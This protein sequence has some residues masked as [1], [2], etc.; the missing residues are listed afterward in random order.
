MRKRGRGWTVADRLAPWLI[1][2]V[3]IGGGWLALYAYGSL[4][5]PRDAGDGLC[6]FHEDGRSYKDV[7]PPEP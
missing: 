3:L 1:A 2:L 7:C 4:V 5:G 6:T